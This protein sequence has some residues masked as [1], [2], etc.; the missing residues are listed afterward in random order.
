MSSTPAKPEWRTARVA[1]AVLIALLISGFAKFFGRAAEDFLAARFGQS[2]SAEAN[3]RTPDYDEAVE[4]LMARRYGAHA[5]VAP[6]A[7]LSI[8]DLL[9]EYRENEFAAAG[10]YENPEGLRLPCIGGDRDDCRVVEVTGM[11]RDMGRDEHGVGVIRLGTKDQ[12]VDVEARFGK[13]E[14]ESLQSLRRGQQVAVRCMVMYDSVKGKYALR[15]V[16]C[17]IPP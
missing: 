2:Q 12:F 5:G 13:A 10:K 7:S 3:Q 15:L 16:R 14:L 17:G 11:I 9:A 1:V 6:I 4:Q 8:D